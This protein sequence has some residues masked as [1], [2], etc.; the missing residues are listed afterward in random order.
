MGSL[1][2][3]IKVEIPRKLSKEQEEL[4]RKYAQT[5]EGEST[6]PKNKKKLFGKF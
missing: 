4:L 5:I 2:V 3:G 6:P 1:H